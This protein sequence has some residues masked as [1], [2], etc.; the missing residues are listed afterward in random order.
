MPFRSVLI[1]A[2][3][4]VAAAFALFPLLGGA[5][6]DDNPAGKDEKLLPGSFASRTPGDR[7]VFP[8]R[9]ST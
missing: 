1:R 4:L 9:P 7:R 5:L 6:A 8:D 3:L 2:A